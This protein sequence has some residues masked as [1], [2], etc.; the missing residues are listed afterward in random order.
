MSGQYMYH[1]TSEE[2]NKK[3]IETHMMEYMVRKFKEKNELRTLLNI[4]ETQYISS[5]RSEVAAHI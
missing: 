1:G 4:Y 3:L 2:K 5:I